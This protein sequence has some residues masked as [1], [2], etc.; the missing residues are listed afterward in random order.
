MGRTV[1]LSLLTLLVCLTVNASATTYYIAANG[2]DSN[3]GTSKTTPWLHAPG[4]TGC[5]AT[6]ASAAPKAGDQFILRG[7]DTWHAFGTPGGIPWAWG[8]SWT[9]NSTNQIYIGVDKTW[10]TG[11]S[12]IRPA[13]DGDNPLT[14]SFLSSACPHDQYNVAFVS[15]NANYVTFDN[16]E[17]RGLC[18]WTAMSS[19]PEATYLN[20]GG[21]HQ[22]ITNNYFHGT[23]I[24]QTVQHDGIYFVTGTG[25]AATYNEVAYNVFD[26]SDG[27]GAPNQPNGW[28]TY[29]DGYNFHHNVVRYVS[30]GLNSPNNHAYAHDNLFEHMIQSWDTPFNHGAAMEGYGALA[31]TPQYVYNNVFRH[32]DLGIL[33]NPNISGLY[34]F[35]NNILYDI[36]NGANCLALAAPTSGLTNSTYILNNT[37]DNTNSFDS[38]TCVTRLSQGGAPAPYQGTVTL[39]NNQF[40]AYFP[41]QLSAFIAGATGVTVID[42][43]GELYQ[44]EATANGQGYTASN[45]Y[46]PAT[47]GSTIDGGANA[48]AVCN[49]IADTTVRAA[50][51]LGGT[52]AV[53]YDAVNHAV[54]IPATPPARPASGSWDVGA[55]EFSGG[56]TQVNPPT[57]LVDTV[58]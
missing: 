44:S 1:Y 12:W 15:L 20:H 28:V 41:Q 14:T 25:G 33:L 48:T 29:Q 49:A 47:G 4:M 45:A 53:S 34:Y 40:I 19:W 50:C 37:F 13:L 39:E 24:P 2:V 57:G 22:Q 26:N 30:V 10:Y 36:G 16:F 42:G 31:N 58:H 38:T 7:G 56:S 5:T 8:G 6:C 52:G 55:Y 51:L 35:F 11:T 3:S 18:A 21:T 17:F 27:S 43:G 23:S 9:G 32:N 46:A 54:I